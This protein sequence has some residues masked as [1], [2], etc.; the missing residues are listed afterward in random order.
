[1]KDK[2]DSNR[3]D[4][5]DT[6]KKFDSDIQGIYKKSFWQD[7]KQNL[8]SCSLKMNSL[9]KEKVIIVQIRI[10]LGVSNLS[11]GGCVRLKLYP[12]VKILLE[13]AMY[14]QRFYIY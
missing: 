12:E 3:S 2:S 1:M 8:R 9:C 5:F 10:E 13:I 14:G 7:Q 4:K 11:L 6:P